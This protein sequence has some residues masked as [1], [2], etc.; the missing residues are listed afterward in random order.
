MPM[1]K[2]ITHPISIILI[3]ICLGSAGVSY[4]LKKDWASGVVLYDERSGN[5]YYATIINPKFFNPLVT[6]NIF[7]TGYA[8]DIKS[9]EIMTFHH[10]GTVKVLLKDSDRIAI[11]NA[12]IF[13]T[14]KFVDTAKL[15]QAL[16]NNAY[17][18]DI[19][20]IETKG[21]ESLGLNHLIMVADE[22][23]EKLTSYFND[24]TK[25]HDEKS[26]KE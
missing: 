20:D 21:L 15:P 9:C 18:L 1:F 19:Y 4:Y 16:Q 22:S 8:Y 11:S 3:L 12:K 25:K 10:L 5:L 6:F 17:P 13:Q 7:N 14:K 2:I 23:A 24:Q 26:S